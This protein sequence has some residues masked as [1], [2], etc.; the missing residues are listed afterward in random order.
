[1]SLDSRPQRRARP[2]RRELLLVSLLAAGTV[3]LLLVL[4][5]FAERYGSRRPAVAADTDRPASTV[6]PT[7]TPAATRSPGIGDAVRDGEFEFVVSRVDCSHKTIGVE[8]LRLTAKG[9][10]CMISLTV[11]NIADGP[12]YFLGHAQE[13]FTADG[14]GYREDE[15]AGIYANQDTHTFLRRLAPG[16]QVTGELVFDIPAAAELTTVE[17]HDSLLS[18]GIKVTLG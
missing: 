7:S 3:V 9:K 12:R 1:M 18:G 8:H 11:R 5:L 15:I 13:A 14:T 6:T 4:G 16:R 17:L 10:Y 2:R